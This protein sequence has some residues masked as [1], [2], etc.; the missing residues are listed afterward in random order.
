MKTHCEFGP[1]TYV[2]EGGAVP[3]EF[4]EALDAPLKWS[5]SGLSSIDFVGIDRISDGGRFLELWTLIMKI[6]L[7]LMLLP[8]I[9]MP[10]ATTDSLDIDMRMK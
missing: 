7:I 2:V 4:E 5:R 10:S 3:G 6:P 8:L 1:N 9:S